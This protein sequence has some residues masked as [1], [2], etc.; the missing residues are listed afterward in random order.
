MRSFAICLAFACLFQASWCAPVLGDGGTV[1]MS[2]TRGPFSITVFTAPT[3]LRAGP[4]DISILVQDARTGEV[5]TNTLV[6]VRLTQEGQQPIECEAT[7]QGATNKLL[8]AAQFEVPEPGKWK[9]ELRT[10]GPEDIG[11]LEGEVEVAERLPR[12]REVWPWIA[13][14]VPVI[15]L[16]GI[17]VRL[18]QRRSAKTA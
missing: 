18:K 1:C 10:E 8:H 11:V 17:H 3:P 6:T 9:I 14:P 2:G 12:W 5:T 7:T 15:V 4:V 16:V 13:W